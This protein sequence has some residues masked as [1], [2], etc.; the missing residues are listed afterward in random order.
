VQALTIFDF[1]LPIH[2][3]ADCQLP[4]ADLQSPDGL[5]SR[6]FQDASNFSSPRNRQSE[7]GNRFKWQSAIG[8]D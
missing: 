4:I 8:N 1:Q 2:I 7:I 3:I 5:K 6:L